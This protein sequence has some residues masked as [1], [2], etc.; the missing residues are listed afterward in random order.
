MSIIN[1]TEGNQPAP[2]G[3]SEPPTSTPSGTP[4]GQPLPEYVTALQNQ[5]A[6]LTKM[7]NGV[8]KGTDKQIGQVRGDIKRILEL[9]G[10]GLDEGAIQRELFIDQMI[11]GQT[12]SA[13][14]QQSVGNEQKNAGIDVDSVITSLQF[15]PNDPALAALKIKHAGNPQELIKAA[16]DLRLSQFTSPSPTPGTGLSQGNG[17][18]NAGSDFDALSTEYEELAK[19]PA[20]NFERMSQIQKELEKIK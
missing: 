8:Q 16:A 20:A 11:A 10:K 7:V 6:D 1:Q 2:A 3:G 4:A 19:N 15:Q 17:A 5:I 12:P 13:Q 18:I 14:V 9:G